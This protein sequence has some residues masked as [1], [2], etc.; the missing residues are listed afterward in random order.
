MMARFTTSWMFQSFCGCSHYSQHYRADSELFFCKFVP[1]PAEARAG[2][3]AE[4]HQ[5]EF[6][7]RWQSTNAFLRCG[8]LVAGEGC[9]SGPLVSELAGPRCSSADYRGL[10]E[11][12][13]KV[14]Y[15]L[16]HIT[17]TFSGTNLILGANPG[18]QAFHRSFRSNTVRVLTLISELTMKKIL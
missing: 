3:I 4:L 2:A 17:M 11:D 16:D 6:T 18:Y 8:L 9:V 15:H 10:P 5:L 13:L 12:F 14:A 7:I 1:R